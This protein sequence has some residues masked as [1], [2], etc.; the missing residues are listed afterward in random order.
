[1]RFPATPGWG[2]PAVVVCGSPPLL[3]WGLPVVVVCFAGGG[4]PCSVC[5]PCV[6]LCAVAVLWRF[7]LVLVASGGSC[8]VWLPC[9]CVCVLAVCSWWGVSYLG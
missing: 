5:L 1:M 2:L 3:S 9:V 8:A 4:V 6:W 7:V